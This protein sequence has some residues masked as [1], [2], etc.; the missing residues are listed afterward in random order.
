[1]LAKALQGN[2]V[3]SKIYSTEEAITILK[4]KLLN[5]VIP[6]TEHSKIFWSLYGLEYA[7]NEYT[8]SEK[9]LIY[10]T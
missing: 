3:A 7:L 8:P 10:L 6:S 5:L 9:E 1:M 2:E 4:S